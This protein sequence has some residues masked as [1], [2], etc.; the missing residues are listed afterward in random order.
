MSMGESEVRGGRLWLYL[1]R[2]FVLNLVAVQVSPQVWITQPASPRTPES[3][4]V[5]V[6]REIDPVVY[7]VV[8][9]VGSVSIYVDVALSISPSYTF[10]RIAIQLPTM[11]PPLWHKTH[12]ASRRQ[13]DSSVLSLS[14]PPRCPSSRAPGNPSL[15]LAL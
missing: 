6:D 4:S 12:R 1:A 8:W 13:C 10:F 2:C 9:L 14:P 5:G 7:N 15:A 3:M 11:N